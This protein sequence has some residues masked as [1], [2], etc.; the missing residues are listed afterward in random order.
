MKIALLGPLDHF[1]GGP[2]VILE[3]Y[4][5]FSEKHEVDIITDFYKKENT[6]SEFEEFP[7]KILDYKFKNIPFIR[8][9]TV[10]KSWLS[11]NLSNYDF[12]IS[13]HPYS[14]IT[15]IKN[16][17]VLV[18]IISLRTL[19]Q[20]Y[21]WSNYPGVLKFVEYMLNTAAKKKEKQ[22]IKNARCVATLSLYCQEKAKKYYGILP[23]VIPL[24]SS[25]SQ[26]HL[27]GI[28]NY[29]LYVGR[30]SPEKRLDLIICAWNYVE[31]NIKLYIVGS[32]K[33]SYVNYLKSLAKNK[34]IDFI[35]PLQGE[36]LRD[37]YSKCLCAIYV[38][39]EEDFGMVALE[40]MTSGKP[41]IVANEGGLGEIVRDNIDGFVIDP[42]PEIIAEKVN[43]LN[44][45]REIAERMG[46]NGRGRAK[47]FDWNIIAEKLLN[48]AK[49]KILNK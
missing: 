21:R 39:R 33:V 8:R 25:L 10:V 22:A 24:G 20:S 18:Y 43:F 1:G 9:F 15:A 41:V 42:K 19:F 23:E 48:L 49:E 32:G 28:D 47:E 45:N 14:H 16:R 37:I 17:N 2:R 31:G 34:N 40:S 46:K 29:C 6:Y 30:L 44:R 36:K 11:L 27:N 7:L 3:L 12:A 5:I 4:K 13:T 35:G 38:P 26:F